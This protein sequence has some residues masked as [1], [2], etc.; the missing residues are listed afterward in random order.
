MNMVQSF[1]SWKKSLLACSMVLLVYKQTMC[2]LKFVVVVV[3][4]VVDG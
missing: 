4:V 1:N 3:V 2:W